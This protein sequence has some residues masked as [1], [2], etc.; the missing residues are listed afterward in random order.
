MTVG[1]H[2]MDLTVSVDNR[3]FVDSVTE[4]ITVTILDYYGVATADLCSDF[5]IPVQECEETCFTIGVSCENSDSCD[6]GVTS[7]N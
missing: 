1:I 5:E 4:T 7:T 6:D 2:T 3:D